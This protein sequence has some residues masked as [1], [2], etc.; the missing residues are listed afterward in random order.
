MSATSKFQFSSSY[1]INDNGAHG[2]SDNFQN[3]LNELFDLV[4]NSSEALLSIEH[5]VSQIVEPGFICIDSDTDTTQE[6]RDSDISECDISLRN[7]FQVLVLN[8]CTAGYAVWRL[9]KKRRRDGTPNFMVANGRTVTIGYKN[10]EW[11]PRINEAVGGRVYSDWNVTVLS[12]P[13]HS[14]RDGDGT[15][16][17]YA[18]VC[19]HDMQRVAALNDFFMHAEDGNSETQILTSIEPNI[20]NDS[21]G[22]PWFNMLVPGS[23]GASGDDLA[24]ARIGFIQDT[25]R[26]TAALRKHTAIDRVGCGFDAQD[27]STDGALHK[28]TSLTDGMRSVMALPHRSFT[29]DF[30]QMLNRFRA[31]V[32]LAFGVPPSELGEQMNSE[33]VGGSTIVVSQGVK[34]AEARIRRLRLLFAPILE[35]ISLKFRPVVPAF[36][37]NEVLG[38]L[39]V[40]RAAEVLSAAYHVPESYFDKERL[41]QRLSI[42]AGAGQKETR[43]SD[44]EKTREKKT[45]VDKLVTE[46]KKGASVNT[47]VS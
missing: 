16:T 37:I 28:E 2:R 4:T 45:T 41:E 35:T 5:L 31:N 25:A 33:R 26:V 1:N 11:E 43:L 44:S 8:L 42:L 13:N 40:E 38:L 21:T 27:E 7:F 12:H 36:Q 29:A 24:A 19:R 17:S 6:S 14:H 46:T 22:K 18:W 47:A 39:K 15:P 32:Y 30:R 34:M 3:T 20:T 23:V 10:G 9:D